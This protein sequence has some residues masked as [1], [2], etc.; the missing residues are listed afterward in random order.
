MKTLYKSVS[1]ALA[2]SWAS[3]WKFLI[4]ER[5]F[6]AP[7]TLRTAR[8]AHGT[9]KTPVAAR[10][11]TRAQ[12]KHPRV[13]LSATKHLSKRSGLPARGTNVAKK[14]GR[15]VFDSKKGTR[16]GGSSR[17]VVKELN[18]P[19]TFFKSVIVWLLA[20]SLLLT[21]STRAESLWMKAGPNAQTHYSDHRAVRAGDILTVVIQETTD[22]TATK[23]TKADKTAKITDSITS[24]FLGS[25]NNDPKTAGASSTN[26]YNGKGNITDKQVVRTNI[27]VMVSDVLPNGNL[28]I[29]GIRAL[30][31]SNEKQYMVLQGVVRADDVLAD[32][33]IL[34]TKIANA[35]VEI[36][37]EGDLSSTQRK[38]WLMKL[39]DFLNPF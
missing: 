1:S 7:K 20:G 37:E 9:S 3:A 12:A 39:N 14:S 30:T 23:E 10:A 17:K 34:S 22:I 36:K 31:Y 26:N 33:T 6:G 13:K 29:E 38:G 19:K 28:V 18:L 24:W 5:S 25:N 16:V 32:N 11:S 35:T 27:T 2:K 8:H 15:I 21:S 4:K